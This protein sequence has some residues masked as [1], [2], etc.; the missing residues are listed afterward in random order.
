MK[1]DGFSILEMSLSLTVAGILMSIGLPIAGLYVDNY[2]HTQDKINI[3]QL[4][5]LI[6]GYAMSRGGFPDPDVGDILPSNNVGMTGLNSYNADIQYYANSLLTETAT[7]QS[8]TTLCDT[9]REILDG[10][11]ASTLP[12][13]CNDVSNAYANCTDSTV[14]AFVIVSSGKNRAMEHENGDGDEE[15][16]NPT[17]KPNETNDY[18]DVVLSYGLPALVSECQKI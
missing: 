15:F 7:G 18:D 14:M 8:F 4:N 16:E 12:A 6:V 10:T 17:K 9:A 11:T 5:D 13:I 2:K 3:K 1:K